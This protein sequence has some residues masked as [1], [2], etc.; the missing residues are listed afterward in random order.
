PTV[1]PAGQQLAGFGDRFLAYL[2]D[3]LIV[4]MAWLVLACP[5][6]IFA[7]ILPLTRL[8]DDGQLTGAAVAWLLAGYAALFLLQFVLIYLYFVEYHLRTGQTVGK[9]VMSLRVQPI[10]PERALDR[11]ILARRFL[12][13]FVAGGFVPFFSWIDGLWQLWDKPLAQTL[14]DKAAETV[15]AKVVQ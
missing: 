6:M 3:G 15:V 5:I 10:Q 14:H 4:G 9:R 12:V 13:Q 1:G 7:L 2:I 8:D 11:G